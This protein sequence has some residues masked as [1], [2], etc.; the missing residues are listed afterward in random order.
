[1]AV[2]NSTDFKL[3]AGDMVEEARRKIGIQADEEP[4]TA[5]ELQT[6]LRALNMMVK[7]WQADGVTAWATEEGEITPLVLGDASYV[8]GVGGSFVPVPLEIMSVRINRGTSDIPM[9]RL[10]RED[11]YDLPNKET[12]GYP[13]QF[14]YE[15]KRSGGTLF[16]WPTPDAGL[17]TLKFTYRRALMDFDNAPDDMDLPQEWH[18]AVLYGLAKRLAENYGVMG[19][20]EGKSIAMEAERT[21]AIVKSF[22][23]GE[24]G[25]TITITPARRY[26]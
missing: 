14:Y 6:G 13:T 16:I 4:M 8:F 19:T 22:D 11:Y 17:G 3:S 7:A 2:S 12:R 24:G 23:T 9:L 1:M 25:G 26:A 20:I 18:E 10:G 5:Q 21:Y 15:R